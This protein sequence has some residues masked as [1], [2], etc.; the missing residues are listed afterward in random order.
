MCCLRIPPS[1]SQSPRWSST[2]FNMLSDPENLDNP[3]TSSEWVVRADRPPSSSFVAFL[4]LLLLNYDSQSLA[5]S[6]A[7]TLYAQ[8]ASSSRAYHIH[9]PAPQQ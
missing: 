5:C 1:F 3:L 7:F 8:I 9:T 4:L 6:S 2:G